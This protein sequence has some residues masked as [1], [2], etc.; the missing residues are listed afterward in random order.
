MLVSATIVGFG[1]FGGLLA[2][3]FRGND[4]KKQVVCILIIYGALFTK[5]AL[6]LF[7]IL[8]VSQ[9][10]LSQSTYEAIMIATTCLI[11][12][13]VICFGI[14]AILHKNY[15]EMDLSIK[16]TSASQ[17]N[18]VAAEIKRSPV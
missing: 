10:V 13:I 12:I 17:I 16:H 2:A 9:R 5:I 3:R 1:G 18:K 11:G 4:I 6:H 7:V 15:A 14:N 8:S